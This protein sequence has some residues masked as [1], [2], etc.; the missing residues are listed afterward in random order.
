MSASCLTLMADSGAKPTLAFNVSAN[1]VVVV[2]FSRVRIKITPP[3]QQ[4]YYQYEANYDRTDAAGGC[5]GIAEHPSS[6]PQLKPNRVINS[7]QHQQ[8][9]RDLFDRN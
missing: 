4:P 7:I 9:L 2:G 3:N 1:L 6:V 8:M 5:S